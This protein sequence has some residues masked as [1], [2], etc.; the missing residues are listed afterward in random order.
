M[1]MSLALVGLMAIQVFWVRTALQLKESE[2]QLAVQGSLQAVVARLEAQENR[3]AV[4]YIMEQGKDAVLA[5]RRYK[6]T[7]ASAKQEAAM[8]GKPP[9]QWP[10]SNTISRDGLGALGGSTVSSRSAFRGPAALPPIAADSAIL[11]MRRAYQERRR[12]RFELQERIK[13]EQPF[14]A[15]VFSDTL[16][17]VPTG[18]LLMET[19]P[20]LSGSPSSMGAVNFNY[21]LILSEELIQNEKLRQEQLLGRQRER[22]EREQ[23]REQQLLALQAKMDMMRM[24]LRDQLFKPKQIDDRVNALQLDTL[25]RSELHTRGIYTAYDWVIRHGEAPVMMPL[26]ILDVAY[27]VKQFPY[28]VQLFPSDVSP[29]PYQLTLSVHSERLYLLKQT[30]WVL[31]TSGAFILCIVLGFAYTVR[32]ILRQKKLSEMKNDFINNMTHEFKT[33]ISTISLATEA[34]REPRVQ[35]NAAQLSRYTQIILDENKRLQSQVERVLQMAEI[36]R[37]QLHLELTPVH[38]ADVLANQV[39]H[40]RLQVEQRGG[41]ITYE[42]LATDDALTADPLHLGNIFLNILDNANKYSP[43]TPYIEVHAYNEKDRFVVSIKD[44]GMGMN[45]E[46]QKRIFE[47]FYRQPTGN[48]HDVKGFGLGLSYVRNMA[49][50]HQATV[51]VKSEPGKGSKFI[52]RFPLQGAFVFSNSQS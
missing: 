28:Q 6:Q 7:Q 40:I 39:A 30:G 21:Q 19:T 44:Q 12:Q 48:L 46:T 47:Q 24:A 1:V 14:W 15:E 52:L 32:T 18:F 41:T 8:P 25:L 38:A 13:Q 9:K 37:G 26:R 50:A 23:Q 22:I 27:D 3:S 35:A 10:E 36:D 42:N 29:S 17:P 49:E 51:E 2:F 31:A 34:L 45:A 16:I 20:T 33:P 11:A 4:Q 5:S 43:E